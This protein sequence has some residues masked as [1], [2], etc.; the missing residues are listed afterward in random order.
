[1]DSKIKRTDFFSDE[2]FKNWINSILKQLSNKKKI[3][4]V[5]VKQIIK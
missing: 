1:M 2:K 5:F 4:N 3:D